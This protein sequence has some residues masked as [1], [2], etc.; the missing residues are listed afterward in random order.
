MGLGAASRSEA[1]M[2]RATSP[3]SGC[4]DAGGSATFGFVD[5]L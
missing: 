2:G 1:A 5:L 4:S 3:F